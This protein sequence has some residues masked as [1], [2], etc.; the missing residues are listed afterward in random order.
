MSA[1]S[2]ATAPLSAQLRER[3]RAAHERAESV[4]FITDLMHGRLDRDA[5]AD[6]AA[7]QYGIYVA[8]EAASAEL[9]GAAR[10]S[11]LVFADLTRTPS[12]EADL[13]FLHGADWREHIAVLPAARAYAERIAQVA[14]DLPRYAAHA[15]TRYLGDLSGGQA[16]KRL[17]Q[18]HYGLGEEGVAFYT[19]A[20]IA[21][22]KVFKDTYREQLDAL[23]L[24]PLE[25]EMAVDE[26]NV[27]FELSTALFAALGERHHA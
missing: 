18:R 19:F 12:I 9:V 26:A 11:S 22:P 21:K 25:L 10:G 17:V 24:S 14:G 15:Y 20:G 7:Q 4:P 13:A 5:Y 23:D 27:A 16:I 8:L 1:P 3:T 6:L 2:I